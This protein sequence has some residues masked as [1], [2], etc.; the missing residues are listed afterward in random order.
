MMSSTTQNLSGPRNLSDLAEIDRFEQTIQAFNAGSLDLDR[1]TAV[2]LQHGVYG[3]RQHGVHMFR[4][5]VPG[6]R[7]TPEQLEAVADIVAAYSQKGIAHVTTRHSIQTHFVP[8]DSTPAA[9][10][11]IAKAG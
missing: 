5:K 2:R 6:G 3:Q 8:L 7:L 11:R 10:R 9:M 4:M 1:M